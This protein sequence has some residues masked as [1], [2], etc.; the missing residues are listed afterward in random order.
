MRFAGHYSSLGI[1]NPILINSIKMD[2]TRSIGRVLEELQ[3]ESAFAIPDTLGPCDDWTEIP[4]YQKSLHIVALLSGRVFVGYPLCRNSEW[5]QTTINYTI[6]AFGVAQHLLKVPSFIRPLVAP[7]HPAVKTVRAH[8]ET[9]MR[10][11]T[12]IIDERIAAMRQDPNVVLPNDA[13]QFLIHNSGDKI[14]DVHTQALLQLNLSIA[15]IHT[16]S[17]NF[18]HLIYDL[19]A[20]PEIIQ[21]LRDEIDSVL[22]SDGGILVKQSMTKLKKMDSFL[23]ESQRFSP[24]NCRKS[25]FQFFQT[26]KDLRYLPIRA[27]CR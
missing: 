7:F 18:T 6:H 16:T 8:R 23:H 19:C 21:P 4:V 9:A 3:K 27:Y 17:M 11:I 14:D 22:A 12:P 10:L 24:P 20:H 1:R 5:V 15:A 2:L 26:P 25:K 13:I